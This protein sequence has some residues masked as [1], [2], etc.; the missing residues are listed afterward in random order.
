MIDLMMRRMLD[1]RGLGERWK[2]Q[3]M[4]A[5]PVFQDE[6]RSRVVGGGG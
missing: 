1:G 3:S 2:S 5:G 4:A 6:S